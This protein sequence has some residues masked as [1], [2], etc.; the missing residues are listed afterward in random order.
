M[1]G[2]DWLFVRSGCPP[3][4]QELVIGLNSSPQQRN[5]QSEVGGLIHSDL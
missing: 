1:T 4:L 3:S 2:C 5:D